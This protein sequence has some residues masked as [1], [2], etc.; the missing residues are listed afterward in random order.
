MEA[1]LQQAIGHTCKRSSSSSPLRERKGKGRTRAAGPL[2]HSTRAR[3]QESILQ[4]E[5][6]VVRSVG[7]ISQLFK[8]KSPMGPK[9]TCCNDW[10]FS[11]DR[12]SFCNLIVIV[13]VEYSIICVDT[14]F[15]RIDELRQQQPQQQ[16]AFAPLRMCKS[17]PCY[18]GG[19]GAAATNYHKPR[20]L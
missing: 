11:D 9:R 12:M 14:V 10:L 3:V 19:G 4:E 18:R 20:R 16:F 17:R 8:Y 5:R 1:G 15:L 13:S 6:R 7:F 2:Q